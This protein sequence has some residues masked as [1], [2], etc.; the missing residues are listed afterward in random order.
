L[1]GVVSD[2]WI[3]P[4]IRKTTPDGAEPDLDERVVIEY[5]N[6]RAEAGGRAEAARGSE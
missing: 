6:G 1:P 2:I 3:L 4:K 5:R